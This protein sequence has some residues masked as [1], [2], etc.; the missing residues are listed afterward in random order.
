VKICRAGLLVVL[1]MVFL[2]VSGCGDGGHEEIVAPI[3]LEMPSDHLQ[4]EIGVS[5]FILGTFMML[6][7]YIV[8]ILSCIVLM[9]KEGTFAKILDTVRMVGPM[10]NPSA[11]Q[12]DR[13]S[14]YLAP[15]TDAATRVKVG[16]IGL[17]AG[18]VTAYLGAWIAL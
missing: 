9:V 5:G 16:Y 11:Q 7:G 3:H 6:N 1:T 14:G 18:L 15:L 10:L 13:L 17:L 2:V 12:P 4:K 8:I